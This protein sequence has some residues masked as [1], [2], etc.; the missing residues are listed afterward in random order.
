M[1]KWFQVTLNLHNGRSASCCLQ[2]SKK[3]DNTSLKSDASKI[4]NTP[5]H[6][7]DRVKLRDGQKIDECQACW[8][9]EENG[10]YS[11]RHYKSGDAWAWDQLERADQDATNV[12]PTYVEVSF[13]SQC[14]LRC[15]YCNPETSSSIAQEIEKYGAYPD[16]ETQMG[17]GDRVRKGSLPWNEEYPELTN[18]YI[19]TFWRW[20]PSVYDGLKVFRVTG[21]E[22]FLSEDT[23]KFIDY[24]KNNPNP[25]MDIQFNSN[26]SFPEQVFNRFMKVFET[27]PSSHYKK[28]V[29]Y[30]SLDSWGE[31]AEYIRHGLRLPVM[32]D[33]I[34]K[35]LVKFPK[36][37]LRFT[38][39]VSI[40]ASFGLKEMLQQ[41]GK[42]KEKWGR[43]RILVSIYPLVFPTF[44]SIRISKITVENVIQE[45]YEFAKSSPSLFDEREVMML[46]ALTQLKAFEPVKSNEL[47][48][49]FY[50]FFKEY[51]RRKK[52][53]FLA[54]FPEF[55]KIWLKAQD[56]VVSQKN[57]LLGRVFSDDSE[58]AVLACTDLYRINQNDIDFQISLA[59]RLVE[60]DP[61]TL[62]F[63]KRLGVVHT[64]V[65]Q[66]LASSIHLPR[67]AVSVLDCLNSFGYKIS[68]FAK[69]FKSSIENKADVESYSVLQTW[70]DFLAKEFSRKESSEVFVD[71][72]RHAQ[73]QE[74]S[75]LCERLLLYIEP[76]SHSEL[77]KRW[78]KSH[79]VMIQELPS[80]ESVVE[81][82]G[83]TSLDYLPG[84]ILSNLKDKKTLIDVLTLCLS[85]GVISDTVVAQFEKNKVSFDQSILLTLVPVSCFNYARVARALELDE[86]LLE[87]FSKLMSSWSADEIAS[88]LAQFKQAGIYCPAKLT[89]SL[90][91]SEAKKISNL[92]WTWL[93]QA[94]AL[95][96]VKVTLQE[97]DR[98]FS[99]N[100][101]LSQ[102]HASLLDHLVLN[103]LNEEVVTHSTSSALLKSTHGKLDHQSWW[104][105]LC[106]EKD[107]ELGWALFKLAPVLFELKSYQHPAGA[108]CFANRFSIINQIN[109]R[110]RLEHW[111]DVFEMLND[112]DRW[113]VLDYISSQTESLAVFASWTRDMSLEKDFEGKLFDSL[114]DRGE[115]FPDLVGSR[116][117]L[118]LGL[119]TWAFWVNTENFLLGLAKLKFSDQV[120]ALS[121]HDHTNL[122][123]S[124]F[125]KLFNINPLLLKE[126]IYLHGVSKALET[127]LYDLTPEASYE[128]LRELKSPLKW[129]DELLRSIGQ[130]LKGKERQNYIVWCFECNLD[131]FDHF[132]KAQTL[133][134]HELWS[135]L[136]STSSFGVDRL[137]RLLDL[138]CHVTSIEL[139]ANLV[140]KDIAWFD[141]DLLLQVYCKHSK[142]DQLIQSLV[143]QSAPTIF[144]SLELR[145]SYHDLTSIEAIAAWHTLGL[146]IT[147]KLYGLSAT[148]ELWKNYLLSIDPEDAF[149]FMRAL[150]KDELIEE[151]ALSLWPRLLVHKSSRVHEFGDWLQAEFNGAKA[152]ASQCDDENYGDYSLT[153]WKKGQR[154]FADLAFI[155]L[156][157]RFCKSSNHDYLLNELEELYPLIDS[158]HLVFSHQWLNKTRVAAA[159]RA[160]ITHLGDELIG[161]KLLNSLWVAPDL[162]MEALYAADREGLLKSPKLLPWLM[163]RLSELLVH[164]DP[165]AWNIVDLIISND[166]DKSMILKLQQT[167]LGAH[168]L[169]KK[170]A[171]KLLSFAKSSSDFSSF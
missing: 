113:F 22:P 15:S 140:M 99:A 106:D 100:H 91:T 77:P 151:M 126:S 92:E 80:V 148:P 61:L 96:G 16:R 13:S 131:L 88:G 154:D 156:F 8:S 69:V 134:E 35:L 168:L 37:E 48:I 152:F 70:F 143:N 36:L 155:Q 90:I 115:K 85:S 167:V 64:K 3:I 28:V 161:A 14:Q 72:L 133:T 21:G 26:L 138:Y 89:I 42:L 29:L 49:D 75:N 12:K 23:F 119:S 84:H 165:L 170:P 130:D 34:D 6:I 162:R 87:I 38:A 145:V 66:Y 33:N 171:L 132:I 7:N 51:D 128:F 67:C 62:E 97:L 24:V 120:Y 46:Q 40:L 144:R 73:K 58:Q 157:K 1:A 166:L 114:R 164:D 111:R 116:P 105:A 158:H 150:K 2:P 71:L 141:D 110:T 11:E 32:M 60:K 135:I 78:Q 18:P 127:A 95:S 112:E 59:K 129:R 169:A 123:S 109:A 122:P 93:D 10:A 44:Q 56:L 9:V 65:Q 163:M 57:H 25:N 31:R 137:S 142:S 19:E 43:D 136:S 41:I 147:C 45:A 125:L 82:V 160:L 104:L 121:F 81:I 94:I 83:D 55:E 68:D 63:L 139:K 4:Y 5:E 47:L 107:A 54:V 118:D 98:Q 159:M 39:T 27:V 124:F 79:Q 102:W 17:R 86:Q 101:K 53:T 117:W 146:D 30:A 108:S 76:D 20:L 103:H 153:Q 52:T 149:T 74:R 50:L